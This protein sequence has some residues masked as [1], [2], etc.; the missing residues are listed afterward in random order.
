MPEVVLV[1]LLEHGDGDYGHERQQP[2]LRLY[3][4]L[5]PEYEREHEVAQEVE[6]GPSPEL[7]KQVAREECDESVL[8]R[9]HLVVVEGRLRA[10]RVGLHAVQHLEKATHA[11]EII[12]VLIKLAIIKHSLL[13]AKVN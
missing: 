12:Y 8:G 3:G 6:V 7:L 11:H 10:Q 9:V 1:S 4:R 2:G 5:V 13:I